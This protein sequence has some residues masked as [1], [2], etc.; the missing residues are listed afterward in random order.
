MLA[1]SDSNKTPSPVNSR[2]KEI[3]RRSSINPFAISNLSQLENIKEEENEQM[4]NPFRSNSVGFANK[5]SVSSVES[6]SMAN[7]FVRNAR[8][9][10]NPFVQSN[11]FAQNSRKSSKEEKDVDGLIEKLSLKIE[12][13]D[14]ESKA[15]QNMVFLE[16][17]QKREILK[18][19]KPF[20]T[21]DLTDN[22]EMVMKIKSRKNSLQLNE[23]GK[24]EVVEIPEVSESSEKESGGN[25]KKEEQIEEEFIVENEI[26]EEERMECQ[27]GRGLQN[28]NVNAGRVGHMQGVELGGNVQVKEGHL[29]TNLRGNVNQLGNNV[30]MGTKTYTQ[31]TTSETVNSQNQTAPLIQPL[32]PPQ[33][34]TIYSTPANFNNQHTFVPQENYSP[35]P[36]TR[37]ESRQRVENFQYSRP[38]TQEPRPKAHE[39]KEQKNYNYI[40][41]R[42]EV[43]YEIAPNYQVNAQPEGPRD[44]RLKSVI[45]SITTTKRPSHIR[46]KVE[47]GQEREMGQSALK[48]STVNLQSNQSQFFLDGNTSYIKLQSNKFQ[49]SQV[50][51]PGTHFESNYLS[52]Q[53]F[54]SNYNQN[55][56]TPREENSLSQ[57]ESSRNDF[58]QKPQKVE[59]NELIQKNRLINQMESTDRLI[60]KKPIEQKPRIQTYTVGGTPA[61]LSFADRTTHDPSSVPVNRRVVLG[62]LNKK[63]VKRSITNGLKIF[64]KVKD[65]QGNIIKQNM[66]QS[67]NIYSSKI[68]S[69]MQSKK[70]EVQR[71]MQSLRKEGEIRNINQKETQVDQ[72]N[73]QVNL[74]NIKTNFYTSSTLNTPITTRGLSSERGISVLRGSYQKPTI[75]SSQRNPTLLY[76]SR[77]IEESKKAFTRPTND[78]STSIFYSGTKTEQNSARNSNVKTTYVRSTRVSPAI[79]VGNRSVG[80]Y[81]KL[82]KRGNLKGG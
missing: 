64:R 52:H 75:R 22:A 34:R 68:L 59:L 44:F 65:S 35:S 55:D 40:S 4:A 46:V 8:K 54:T 5:L 10:S 49:D 31:V 16:E 25:E 77:N 33:P 70:Q 43:T 74:R 60:T 73:E 30:Q 45:K 66:E 28:V 81:R 48:D 29:G 80:Y 63:P 78:M 32:R 18:I 7:P 24:G 6:E 37:F 26:E 20:L 50:I 61:D 14:K 47:E 11:P 69:Q 76:S 19:L 58:D 79:A 23:G 2:E 42:Q 82:G 57:L 27:L 71:S 67:I 12:V 56:F 62:S 36:Q 72:P 41:N 21:K 3:M 13:K 53:N 38:I 39:I 15:A 1:Y 9:V 17:N 51:Q